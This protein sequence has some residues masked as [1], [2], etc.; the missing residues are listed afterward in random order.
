MNSQEKLTT[1][2]LEVVC[3]LANGMTA[4]EVAERM[5]ISESTVKRTL[6]AARKRVGARTTPHLVS[7]VI[8]QGELTWTNDDERAPNDQSAKVANGGVAE[9]AG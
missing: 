5:F 2:Q 7:I 6:E 8:A 3:H 4:G 1:R 9:V